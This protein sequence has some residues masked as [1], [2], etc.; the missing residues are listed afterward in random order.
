MEWWPAYLGI[1]VAVG[2]LAGLL[3]IAVLAGCSL[4][5]LAAIVPLYASRGERTYAAL[6]ILEII[7]MLLAASG[8]LAVSH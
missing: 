6:C 7:V 8:L 4:V 2:F 3:G 1:G 5:C